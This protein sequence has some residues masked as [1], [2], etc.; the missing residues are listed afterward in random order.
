[1][2]SVFVSL[3][4]RRDDIIFI[5]SLSVS[6]LNMWCPISFPGRWPGKCRMVSGYRADSSSN[7]DWASIVWDVRPCSLSQSH[8]HGCVAGRGTTWA[9]DG[10]PGTCR[11]SVPLF[12]QLATDFPKTLHTSVASLVPKIVNSGCMLQSALIFFNVCPC[13]TAAAR[14]CVSK[15][16]S[17]SSGL[18][19]WMYNFLFYA[20]PKAWVLKILK[21]FLMNQS[22]L[23]WWTY[24]P[25]RACDKLS[26]FHNN[27]L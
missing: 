5:C 20:S 17:A 14:A 4:W 26:V 11:L 1:M 6:D 3:L 12:V 9:T 21:Q 25:C 15:H 19:G 10:C 8:C 22:H 18:N 23:N 24:L 13:P 7:K 2:P 27:L 16:L